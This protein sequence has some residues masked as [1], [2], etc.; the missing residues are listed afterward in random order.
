MRYWRI[1]LLHFQDAF[2][3][4][5]RSLVW[6][7]ISLGTGAI[8]IVYWF[9]IYKT[10]GGALTNWSLSNVS[11]YYLL[12][13]IVSSGIMAHHDE[14]IAR[15]DIQEGDLVR[16]L[17]RPF[18]YFWLLYFAEVPWRII[19]G[20]FG[21]VVFILISFIFPSLISVSHSLVIIL[22]SF[23]IFFLASLLS[24]I[25]KTILGLSAFWVTDFRGVQ[26]VFEVTIL[27]LGG[28]VLPLEFLPQVIKETSFMLPFSYMAYFPIMAIQGKLVLS[29]LMQVIGIQLLWIGILLV[30]YKLMLRSGLKMFTGV[31]Q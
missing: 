19:Q 20:G 11:S 29:Q 14:D 25:F 18:S 21:V 4:K 17:L 31:G 23:F 12:L 27:V 3:N 2:Y 6:F 10:Q 9:A 22:L 15:L 30:L 16:H 28:F 1:F 8:L 24:F 7:L 13:I 26:S 5:S